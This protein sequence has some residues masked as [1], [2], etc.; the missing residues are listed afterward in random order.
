MAMIENQDANVGRVLA[1]LDELRVAANTIVVYFSD[2]G[3][4]TRRWN[5]GMKGIKGSVD[6]GGVRSVCYL[7]WPAGLPSG[8]EVKQ[9]T[10]AIDLGPT[11]LSL[12]KV[13]RVGDKPYDGRDMH[14]L[15][16]GLV[17][18]WPERMIFSTWAGK[19]S[20]RTDRW[21][22][23]EDG[24]L[25]DMRDTLG[26]S[27]VSNDQEPKVRQRLREAVNQWRK[28]ML[29]ETPEPKRPPID[30]RPFPIGYREFPIAM[31]PARDGEPQGEVKRSSPAPNCSYFVNWR[32]LDDRMVWNIDV[33][34]AGKYEVV[35]DYTCPEADAG[36]LLELSLGE[37]RLTG[38]VS[39][40]WDPPLYD[41]QD[42][43]PRPHGE[44]SMKE[45][46]PLRLGEIELP[47]GQGALSL[48]ALEIP[49]KAVMDVRRVTLTLLE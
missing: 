18:D 32:S 16:K 3:P 34:T 21:R 45:F 14:L 40:G 8:R 10:G 1:K 6:E 22:L 31:L 5:G 12:A 44:S 35:I 25:Y 43:L 33:H 38:R 26:Q 7:R 15:L 20:V 41:N 42:T 47:A 17:K 27:R 48:R 4:N 37:S 19:I 9:V 30:P 13:R 23:D 24:H 39:P 2:N 49:G 11:L 46:R 28:E 29:G 36:S